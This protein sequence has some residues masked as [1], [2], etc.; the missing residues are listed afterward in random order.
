MR[1]LIP[2]LLLVML[3]AMAQEPQE[4]TVTLV[5]DPGP[6]GPTGEAGGPGPPGIPG[7]DGAT[8]ATGATGPAGDAADL[9]W[10][11]PLTLSPATAWPGEPIG[12]ADLLA[13][14]QGSEPSGIIWNERFQKYIWV[15][16]NGNPYTCMYHMNADGSDLTRIG[17]LG[18]GNSDYEGITWTGDSD[19]IYILEEGAK[20]VH[21][22]NF[23]LVLE[24]LEDGENLTAVEQK[25]SFS[26]S[27]VA[28]DGGA[29]PEGL[30]FVP[31]YADPEGGVFVITTQAGSTTDVYFYRL[32]IKS[33]A[34]STTSAHLSAPPWNS[35]RDLPGASN[36]Q[37]AYYHA[38]R[39]WLFFVA[40]SGNHKVI[41]TDTDINV[42]DMFSTPN[43]APYEGITA[44]PGNS[45]VLANDAGGVRKFLFALGRR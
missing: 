24:N 33:S 4:I 3:P 28:R 15:H 20:Q 9:P 35:P 39:G 38:E 7:A 11:W 31:D 44:G 12:Y 14:P 18:G 13:N 17:R 29:G 8:G 30:T 22:I 43:A 5:G 25:R 26:V 27:E 2:V 19:M 16:D 45:I 41:V 1:Y 10:D 6:P 21:E 32:E 36:V 40:G 42:I 37:G 34:T 23:R